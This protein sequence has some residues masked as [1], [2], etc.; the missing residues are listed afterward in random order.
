M[1]SASRFVFY[2]TLILQFFPAV[3]TEAAMHRQSAAGTVL[4]R[5][6]FFLTY[7]LLLFPS[8]SQTNNQPNGG[9]QKNDETDGCTENRKQQGKDRCRMPLRRL[10]ILPQLAVQNRTEYKESCEYERLD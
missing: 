7:G 4:R 10:R 2:W 1:R 9:Y 6:L 3:S 8:F 5:H